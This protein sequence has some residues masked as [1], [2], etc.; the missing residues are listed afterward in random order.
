[1]NHARIFVSP[2]DRAA[3]RVAATLLAA[4]LGIGSALAQGAW[5]PHYDMP[6][7]GIGGRVFGLATWRNELIAC[8]YAK[9]WR[10]GNQLAHVGRFD[11]VR[12]HA[13]G[14]GLNGAARDAVEFQGDLYVGGR[15]TTAGGAPALGVARWDGTQWHAVGAGF[16]ISPGVNAEVWALCVHQGQL[17]AAGEFQFS[18]G[19]TTSCIAQ[20]NGSQWQAV[21]GGLQWQLTNTPR[22][23]TLTSDGIDLYVGGEFD[24]AGTT[25]TSHVARWNGATWQPLGGGINSFGYGIVTT[26][27]PFQGRIYCGGI[28][29]VAG[30]VPVD[31]LA[32]WDGTQWSA[33]GA[34]V[35]GATYGA[36]VQSLAVYHNELYVGG[37]FVASGTTP[38]WQI[39]R[40]DG[41]QLQP[42]GGVNQAEVNPPTVFAMSVWNDRLYCGGEFQVAGQPDVPEQTLGVYHVAAYDGAAWSAVGEGLGLD[43]EVH[44]LGSWQGQIVVGGRFSIAG[45]HQAWALARFD[46]D[47]W[48]FFGAF[49]GLMKG[50]VEHNGELWV[51]GQFYTVNG[52]PADGVARFD[53][54]QWHAIGSGPGPA[55]ASCIAVYQNMIHIG[56]TGS[57]KRW[58]GTAWQ[59]FTPAITGQINAMHVHQGVLYL[60]GATPFHAGAPNLFAW[61]GSTL[62][63]P[64][65]GC[66]N[67]VESLASFGGELLVGGRFTTAGGV[68]ARSIARWNGTTWSTFGIGI[69]GST[70]RAM[71]SFG[72]A[73]VIGGDFNAMQGAPADYVAR[74]N[75]SGWVPLAAAQ[76][77]GAI[78]ALLADDARGELH[79][80]G[81]YSRIGS[82]DCGHLGVF[83]ATPFWTDLG[84]ALPGAQRTPSLTGDGRLF[85]GSRTRWRLSSAVANGLAVFATGG[86][87]ANVPLFGGTLVP[88]PDILLGALTDGI[89]TATLQFAWPG[90]ASGFQAWTQAWVLDATGPQG[91]TASNGV[92]LR[93]P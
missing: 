88:S 12:W 23:R 56:S 16:S 13:L 52:V 80:G 19:T 45:G 33:V 77:N 42:I 64:G 67:A 44:V 87:P 84:S 41:S 6:G 58:N 90:G 47:D 79:A 81:W 91:F 38:L 36:T 62:A 20:W 92:W 48:R 5:S 30:S 73:L 14:S 25:P 74:W 69:Q 53:G 72:G 15:F 40:F 39:A 57:P 9:P 37:H 46:G 60:G 7:F 2:R 43:N 55:R 78:F 75:G 63:V 68:P 18:G 22:A 50:M 86:A 24:R 3:P 61:N 29:G 83:E 76:P 11:G 31:N 21:G 34:G 82:M 17:F 71:T 89:G 51:A 1:M 26:L 10:D 66:N 4:A 35:Q 27:L 65:G 70:V 93:A 8:T 32:A 54:T 49:D 59:T 28:F 85:P